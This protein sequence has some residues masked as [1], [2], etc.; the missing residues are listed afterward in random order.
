[1]YCHIHHCHYHH[2]NCVPID[3][4][5][6][7]RALTQEELLALTEEMKEELKEYT[8]D[9]KDQ[10]FSYI[11]IGLNPVEIANTFASLKEQDTYILRTL[12]N[13]IDELNNTT[14]LSMF[15]LRTRV[16]NLEGQSDTIIQ[17]LS[18]LEGKIDSNTADITNRTQRIDG[19]ENDLTTTNDELNK[20]KLDTGI[21]ATSKFG[22]VE[23]T[24]ADK[25]T[26]VVTINDIYDI[27]T[28]DYTEIF[29]SIATVKKG[30]VL[31]LGGKT[32]PAT[33]LPDDIQLING[34]IETGGKIVPM[35]LT[36][37][38]HPASGNMGV[39]LD[40]GVTHFWC[41][42]MLHDED[43]GKTMLFVKHAYRH[44]TS[45]TSP[46]YMYTSEDNGISLNTVKTIYNRRGYS[47]TE[48]RARIM[49]NGRYGL[50]LTILNGT[51]N[52]YTNDFLYSD[53]SG[54]TWQSIVDVCSGHFSYSEMLQKPNTT[55]TF[56]VYGYLG[57]N[58]QI[59]KTTNN[60]LTWTNT[61]VSLGVGVSETT[62]VKLPNELKWIA[63]IRTTT[64]LYISTSTDMD[65]WSTPKNTD[66][67]LGNNPIQVFIEHGKLYAYLFMRD[68]SE[69][70]EKQ[71]NT[72]LLIDDYTAVYDNKYFSNKTFIPIF[73]S[74][75]RSLGYMR[76]HKTSVGNIFTLNAGEYDGSTNAPSSS[77]VLI[78]SNYSNI[79]AQPEQPKPNWFRNGRFDLWSRGTTFTSSSNFKAADGW[80]LN[81]S[82]STI[83]ASRYKVPVDIGQAL[84][85]R[86]NY[87]MKIE[88]SADDYVGF[89][90]IDYS[91]S[92]LS[93]TQNQVITVQVWGM[94]TV[95]KLECGYI[96]YF[97][98]DGS[99]LKSNGGY[100][101]D[102]SN[103]GDTTIWSGIARIPLPSV[104]GLTITDGAYLR[105]G[106]QSRV[107]EAWDCIIFGANAVKSTKLHPYTVSNYSIDDEV[108]RCVKYLEVVDL[109]SDDILSVGFARSASSID[110][111][112]NYRPKIKTPTITVTGSFVFYPSNISVSG[113]TTSS[114]SKNS[115]I[116]IGVGATSATIGQAGF[117]RCASGGS[118]K[119]VIDC[120]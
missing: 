23:R 42:D 59:A 69:T 77:K 12:T 27:A 47:V 103:I 51:T 88:A 39:I 109:G 19:L 60:G 114:A 98:V 66:V 94:G 46:I 108:A 65:T 9:L 90:Q 44:A 57:G 75:D 72:L 6:K 92:A 58:L 53:D 105:I 36:A 38:P 28:T 118:G 85:F 56:Y 82:G 91:A 35:P 84:P 86:P 73:Q 63:F 26:D 93:S 99:P 2:C 21:T 76:V 41:H 17:D 45:L 112:I 48:V 43:T 101:F 49:A 67:L 119:M 33:V 113:I 8:V 62:V 89:Y 13:K 20:V 24:Q 11:D 32:L 14:N 1:M 22:G 97:G 110:T 5:E 83:T 115:A 95:P 25:N 70:L 34:A 3:S 29:N 80:Q 71:N 50:F 74:I 68:F 104:E 4:K 54:E 16:T 7:G 52:A 18:V 30:A 31:D 106:V 96:Q 117:L 79:V 107:V 81:V 40:D 100:M 15:N 61:S 111:M 102:I 10:I 78:G 87:G 64:Y 55:N 37:K 116:V 120:E